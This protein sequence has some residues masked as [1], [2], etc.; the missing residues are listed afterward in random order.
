MAVIIALIVLGI[1]V[2]LILNYLIRS[3]V[4]KGVDAAVYAFR[5]KAEAKHP[6]VQESLASRYARDLPGQESGYGKGV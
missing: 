6:P 5:K 3:G 1:A 2:E 4:N